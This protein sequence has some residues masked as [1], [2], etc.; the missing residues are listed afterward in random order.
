VENENSEPFAKK[1]DKKFKRAKANG[2]EFS[3]S[4][5]LHLLC[6]QSCLEGKNII[7]GGKKTLKIYNQ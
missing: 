3:F 6:N 2:S 7:Q 5:G 4:T 1:L